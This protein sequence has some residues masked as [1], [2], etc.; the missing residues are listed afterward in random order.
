MGLIELKKSFPF[1]AHEPDVPSCDHGWFWE[2]HIELLSGAM[3]SHVRV[4]LELGSWLGKSARWLA[5]QSPNA[6]VIA[7]DHWQG[8]AEHFKTPGLR[9][10]LPT[11]Y[12]TFIKNCWTFRDRMIPLRMDTISGMGLVNQFRIIPDLIYID[13]GH[14]YASAYAD[15]SNALRLF[16]NAALCGDDFYWEGVNRAITEH[17]RS[18]SMRASYKKNQWWKENSVFS[19]IQNSRQVLGKG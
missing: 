11:L 8:S 6:I 9:A 1:P 17:V 3:G 12:D 2:S 19:H 13:A 5:K 10:M 16:P 15:V 14:D 7:V 4:I 18:G